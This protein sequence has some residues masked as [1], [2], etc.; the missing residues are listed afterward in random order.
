MNDTSKETNNFGVLGWSN[1]SPFGLAFLGLLTL[2]PALRKVIGYLIILFILLAT[3]F[4]MNDSFL[5]LVPSSDMTVSLIAM[6]GAAVLF[7]PFWLPAIILSW[8]GKQVVRRIAEITDEPL[9]CMRH[10][11]RLV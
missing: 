7:F 6:F 1:Y 3:A 2:F 11:K 10:D 5:H 9:R 8:L 4:A